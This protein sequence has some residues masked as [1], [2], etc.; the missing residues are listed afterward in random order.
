MGTNQPFV[1]INVP[2]AHGTV[3]MSHPDWPGDTRF[4]RLEAAFF[5]TY[6]QAAQSER[7]PLE[8][9]FYEFFAGKKGALLSAGVGVGRA[10]GEHL[11]SPIS[12]ALST[13]VDNV[14]NVRILLG[15]TP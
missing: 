8:R 12:T 7:S 6:S 15:R 1:K 10:F 2:F 9:P 11:P 3:K 13:R 4:L 14:G 5:C